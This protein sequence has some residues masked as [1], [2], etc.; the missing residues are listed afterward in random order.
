MAT[1]ADDPPWSLA[2]AAEEAWVL[3]LYVAGGSPRSMGA[4]R[5]V[6]RL[7]EEH[8]AGRVDLRI[9][10]IFQQPALA[11]EAQ[12]VAAPTLVREKPR[13]LRRFIGDLTSVAAFASSLGL[14]VPPRG[15]EDGGS[16]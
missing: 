6:T 11:A 5:N 12:L 7:C 1:R 3:C 2:D 4:I 13:P 9:V 16:R 8:L 10:D 14:A 15:P